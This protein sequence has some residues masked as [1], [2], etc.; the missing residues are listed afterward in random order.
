MGS[1][2]WSKGF[3]FGARDF[4]PLVA[5]FRSS[6]SRRILKLWSMSI[7]ASCLLNTAETGIAA[8]WVSLVSTSSCGITVATGAKRVPLVLLI[9]D[10]ISRVYATASSILLGRFCLT[11]KANSGLSN[12]ARYL[13]RESCSLA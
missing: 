11:A 2:N 13:S 1:Q 3:L 7:I 8:P 9:Y 5:T 6:C 12:D 4:S 10:S